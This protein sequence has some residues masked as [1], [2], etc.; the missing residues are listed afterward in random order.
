MAIVFN[1]SLRRGAAS[2]YT[3]V[4][5]SSMNQTYASACDPSVPPRPNDRGIHERLSESTKH[6]ADADES[7][8]VFVRR[9]GGPSRQTSPGTSRRRVS[10]LSVHEMGFS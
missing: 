8:R 3:H 1:T 7:G 6:F 4:L 9:V 5:S 10:T 2:K